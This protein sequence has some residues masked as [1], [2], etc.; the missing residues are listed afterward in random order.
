MDS[1]SVKKPGQTR[2]TRL[3][4]WASLKAY[5]KSGEENNL[6]NVLANALEKTRTLN[7][8]FFI[9]NHIRPA[10]IEPASLVPETS[11]VSILLRALF[12]KL[13]M[14]GG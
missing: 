13:L 12:E 10:G 6:L 14:T 5:L 2:G 3:I 9:I 4:V 7:A 11:V 1:V 8:N